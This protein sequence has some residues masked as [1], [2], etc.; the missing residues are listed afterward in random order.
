MGKCKPECTCK[1]HSVTKPK[2]RPGCT[3]ARHDMS[4][5]KRARI[6]AAKAGRPLSEAHK[7]A[8]RCPVGCDCLKHGLRNS[9]QFKADL[10]RP[11]SSGPLSPSFR[12]GMEGTA[13][14]RSWQA[15]LSRCSNPDAR[16]YKN[17]GGRGITVCDRW[18]SFENFL[19]DMGVR[20]DGLTLDRIDNDGNYEP[21]NCRWATWIEQA[22][23][24]RPMSISRTGRVLI[25]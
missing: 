15:M 2:C 6:S 21:G 13:T 1:R 23:N 16:G 3:C 10:P 7:L 5:E 24:R 4:V 25:K 9:G 11:K 19:A 14:Y 18:R 8:L 17:Y 22:A 12:H 20:P